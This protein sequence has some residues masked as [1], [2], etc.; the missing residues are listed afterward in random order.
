MIMGWVT[1]QP[2]GFSSGQLYWYKGRKLG[3]YF[4]NGIT[5][6]VNSSGTN[7]IAPSANSYS[8][9]FQGGATTSALTNNL[10]VARAGA[11]FKPMTQDN[12]LGLSISPA[13]VLTGHFY[14]GSKTVQFKGGY[15]GESQ[16]GAGFVL[17]GGNEPGYF[18]LE[19]Q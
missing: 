4:T 8:I 18:F 5:T 17:D 15:F 10:S 12:R 19:A 11:Q 14:D 13:G 6:F 3:K 7:Y 9:V 1:N 2:S 16:G